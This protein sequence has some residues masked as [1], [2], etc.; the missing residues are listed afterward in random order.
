MKK[1]KQVKSYAKQL[2]KLSLEDGVLSETRVSGVLQAVA[3]NPPRGYAAVLRA[4]LQLAEREVSKSTAIVSH[5]GQL[6]SGTL[7]R[8]ASSMSAKYGRKIT[9]VAKEDASLIAGLK[10]VVDCDVYEN[11]AASVLQSLQS[12]LS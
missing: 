1:D 5:V 8:I 9:A 3:K 6:N 10:V 12:S 4:Y 11:S 2:L 7:E